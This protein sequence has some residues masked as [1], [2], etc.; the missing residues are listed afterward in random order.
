MKMFTVCRFCLNDDETSL[1]LIMQ[2]DDY[3]LTIEDMELLTGL[4]LNDEQ[5]YSYAVCFECSKNLEMLGAFREL[6]LSNDAYF[7]QV[8]T[9][10]YAK[11]ELAPNEIEFAHSVTIEEDSADDLP[12]T[13]QNR[14]TPQ[15]N[16]DLEVE[17]DDYCSVRNT[18]ASAQSFVSKHG[19][20]GED[21]ED[22]PTNLAKTCK[23]K[24]GST[25]I[26]DE[27]KNTN[28]PKNSQRQLCD[29]CGKMVTNI[30]LHISSHTKETKY[31]CVHCPTKMTH[32]ANLLRHIRA[33]HLKT[34]V[35]S[36]EL[37][38]KGF[39][40]NNTYKSHMRS[41]HDIG[42][43]YKCKMCS[44]PFKYP[45][46]L[47]DHVQRFHTSGNNYKCVV[48]E[49]MF[50]TKQ[51]LKE[52]ENVHTNETPHCCKYCPKRFKSRSARYAHQLTH[53]DI[54]FSCKFCDKSYRYKTLLNIHVRKHHQLNVSESE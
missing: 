31:K 45:S 11:V 27:C 6:C 19:E 30:V 40:H 13:A 23:T 14:L 17:N 22:S 43:T 25:K 46:G 1:R 29:M 10:Q 9:M 39:T 32:P 51:A 5:L 21:H 37:C 26:P 50:K 35:K 44:K 24:C 49:K 20:R 8:C 38:G 28:R 41:Q 16:L 34:I 15:S 52:H 36:C 3:S 33:V 54:V 47:R 7:R 2:S 12:A 18:I 53:S 48:C 42:E 4:Q